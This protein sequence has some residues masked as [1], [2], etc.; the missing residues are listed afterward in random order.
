MASSNRYPGIDPK[1]V[2]CIR[3]HA[4]RAYGS[5]PAMEIEDIEQ[6]LMLHVH[7]RLPRFDP[8]RG[9]LRTFVDRIARNCIANLVQ[10]ARA[11]KRAPELDIISLDA[12]AWSHDGDDRRCRDGQPVALDP[13]HHAHLSL[14][15][16]L[17]LRIDL[18]RA[19]DQLPPSLRA[20]L[21]GLFGSTVADAARRSGSSRARVY[22]HIAAIRERF[23]LVGFH[24]YQA[25][26]DTFDLVSVSE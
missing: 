26:P 23:R 1:V 16:L 20:P 19:H 10:A 14:E 22:D 2:A 7:R 8:G 15:A 6:E 24:H 5:I 4:R 17:N 18:R 13:H 3:H 12:I 25:D 11:Q 9:S 21:L